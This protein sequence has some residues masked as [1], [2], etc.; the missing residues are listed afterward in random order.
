MG[1]SRFRSQFENHWMSLGNPISGLGPVIFSMSNLQNAVVRGGDHGPCP[2][3]P[4]RTVEVMLSN[5]Y[6]AKHLSSQMSFLILGILS[7][8]VQNDVP[9]VV[10][11]G[12]RGGTPGFQWCV[13]VFK[14]SHQVTADSR[15]SVTMCDC[16]KKG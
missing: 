6:F 9:A 16:I 5:H 15:H 14:K 2:E 11:L 3:L 8:I 7:Q 12:E 13:C 1:R 10:G 4:R